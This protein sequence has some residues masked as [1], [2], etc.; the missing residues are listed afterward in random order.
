MNAEAPDWDMPAVTLEQLT[1]WNDL[2]QWGRRFELSPAGTLFVTPLPDGA[3]AGVVSRLLW[4][5]LKAGWPPGQVLHAVGVRAPGPG[6]GGGWIPDLT[7]W[8]NP[9]HGCWLPA[10]DLVVAIEIVTP[11]S[12]AV[13]RHVKVHEYAAAGIPRYW[14]VDE[15]VTMYQLAGHRRYEVS[16]AVTLDCLLE[17]P[18]GS[19][20]PGIS[21]GS[22]R[23]APSG[24]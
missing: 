16:E 13:D 15:S 10:E 3:H 24:W 18:A 11:A 14:L 17:T 22:G 20:L 19:Y 4:W 6:I 7:V 8:A 21:A 9:V 12:H 1:H 2:D 5:F 23:S